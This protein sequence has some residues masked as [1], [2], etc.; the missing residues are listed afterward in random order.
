[1]AIFTLPITATFPHTVSELADLARD[2]QAY[3]ASGPRP[4]AHVLG[5]LAITT[6]WKHAW[7]VP[8]SV[9]LVSSLSPLIPLFVY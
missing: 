8:G 7:S 6:L 9:L 1:M 5:V 2:L 3:S 4:K